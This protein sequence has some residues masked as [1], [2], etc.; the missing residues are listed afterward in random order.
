M[1]TFYRR[2]IMRLF[3]RRTDAIVSLTEK[4][5]EF[6]R[7]H[8]YSRVYAIHNP[9][10]E[11]K[12]E[13]P[14]IRKKQ[15]VTVGNVN[16][17]KGM[18]LL[19]E[20]AQRVLEKNP[21]WKWIVAGTGEMSGFLEA[22]IEEDGLQEGLILAGRVEDVDTLLAESSIFVLTS[23]SEGL[24]MCLLEAK[25]YRVPIVSFDIEMGPDEIITDG[26][27]GYLIRPFDTE[28]MAEK[29]Q[30]LMEDEKRRQQFSAQVSLG[31]EKFRIGTI[32]Q[33]WNQI[34]VH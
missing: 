26:V 18:D 34:L 7:T 2:A 3:T 13:I 29:L 20:V 6:F 17:G 33:Q 24:P 8:N 9:M 19:A 22:F 27:N 5:A 10:P 30:M 21:D 1:Q 31:D 16:R 14:A 25:V 15:I 32:I 11:K 23:R 4:D 28:E 12:R